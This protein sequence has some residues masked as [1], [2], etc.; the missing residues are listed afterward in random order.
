M[1]EYVDLSDESSDEDDISGTTNKEEESTAHLSEKNTMS[2]K[3][4]WKNKQTVNPITKQ[5]VTTAKIKYCISVLIWYNIIQA[6]PSKIRATVLQLICQLNMKWKVS[7]ILLFYLMPCGMLGDSLISFCKASL[8]WNCCPQ[9]TEGPDIEMHLADY[10]I[11][12]ILEKYLVYNSYIIVRW[13]CQDCS[14]ETWDGMGCHQKVGGVELHLHY[15]VM[16]QLSLSCCCFTWRELIKQATLFWPN[17]VLKLLFWK[18]QYI[19]L[20][21]LHW[22]LSRSNK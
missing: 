18:F 20:I 16:L 15:T 14:E 19:S 3:K 11:T 22:Y 8:L 2:T 6:Q 9:F 10:D 12:T 17:W 4:N 13:C 1:Q 7:A 21:P 5:R